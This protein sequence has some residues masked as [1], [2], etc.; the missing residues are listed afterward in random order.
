[1]AIEL[2]LNA[3]LFQAHFF[4][5]DTTQSKQMIRA[6][7]KIRNSTWQSIQ[8][9]KGLH[10]EQIKGDPGSFTIRLSLQAR[11]VVVRVGDALR[12]ESLHFD[13]DSAYH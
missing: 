11:A 10:W 4:A 2:D 9:D 3:P 13:H 6:L 7:K 8:A 5:L 12:F 1:V